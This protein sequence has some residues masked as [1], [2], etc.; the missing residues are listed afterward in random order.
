MS[1]SSLQPVQ[2]QH[3]PTTHRQEISAAPAPSYAQ[4]DST[5]RLST[6]YM[7]SV[8]PSEI[9]GPSPASNDSSI[10]Y[11]TGSPEVNSEE[12]QPL[13]RFVVRGRPLPTPTVT[14]RPLQQWEAIVVFVGADGFDGVL[15]DL[16]VSD[17][18]RERANFS[19][20]EVSPDDRELLTIGAVFYWFIGYEITKSGQRKLVSSLRFRRLPAWT[21]SEIE[22]VQREA[23]E[24]ESLLGIHRSAK[25]A[26][27]A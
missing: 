23:D 8:Q 16:T 7:I 22:A 15:T 13:E 19:F 21:R 1:S 24:M 14:S 9:A 10:A 12:K 18:P 11:A 2:L 3:S 20:E 17:R 4:P 26:T 5:P 27:K 6:P 25:N